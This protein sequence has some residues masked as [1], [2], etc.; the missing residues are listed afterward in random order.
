[1]RKTTKRAA[2]VTATFGVIAAGSGIAYAVWNTVSTTGAAASA[3]TLKALNTK[4]LTGAT[5]LR[6]GTSATVKFRVT[7]PNDYAV[8]VASVSTTGVT[9]AGGKDN[10]SC[11]GA[12]NVSL[13]FPALPS[14]LGAGGTV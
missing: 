7:N 13:S 6:P 1:M 8:R 11:V 4:Q 12:D 5:G 2:V 14:S 9:V 3:T 10:A